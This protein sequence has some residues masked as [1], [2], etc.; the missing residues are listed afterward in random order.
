[1]A[2]LIDLE[3]FVR[4]HRPH[5][6][7]TGNATEPVRNGYLLTVAFPASLPNWSVSRWM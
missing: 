2:L 4:D 7:L 5:G 1:M 6:S 3:E